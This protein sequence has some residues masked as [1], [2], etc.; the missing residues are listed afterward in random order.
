MTSYLDRL[1]KFWD[2]I[3]Q[4]SDLLPSFI[5]PSE[6]LSRFILT[7]RYIKSSRNSVSPQAFMPST[8][9]RETSVYRTEQCSETAIWEIGD[10][11]VTALH[12]EH[13]PIVGRGDLITHDILNNRHLRVVTSPVPHPRHANIVDWPVE[14]EKILMIATEL[15]HGA[16]LVI[17]P[18]V[19]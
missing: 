8:R 15:A 11:Y 1:R 17:R 12:P 19:T 2:R 3:F 6:R 5:D 14:K 10:N 13:K 9:T 7:R 16:T 4:K 18:P